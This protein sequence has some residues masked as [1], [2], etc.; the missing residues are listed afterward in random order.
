MKKN[1]NVEFLHSDTDSLIYKVFTEFLF[2]K[3]AENEELKAFFD[4]STYPPTSPL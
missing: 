4:F 2:R 3:L 1:L